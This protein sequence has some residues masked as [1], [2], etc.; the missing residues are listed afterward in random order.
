MSF[1]ALASVFTAF[2][3]AKNIAIRNSNSSRLLDP[4][5]DIKNA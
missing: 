2:I 3:A 5:N 1:M 4:S